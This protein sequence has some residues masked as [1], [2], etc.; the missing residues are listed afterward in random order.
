MISIPSDLI[1]NETNYAYL[2]Q[3]AITD[4]K[5]NWLCWIP[6]NILTD[7]LELI[8]GKQNTILIL[9]EYINGTAR[10]EIKILAKYFMETLARCLAP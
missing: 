6:K 7:R 4:S 5:Q 2:I 10:T 1:I 3:T 8:P 9:R